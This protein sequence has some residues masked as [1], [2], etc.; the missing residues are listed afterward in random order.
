MVVRKYED[1]DFNQ[2]SQWAESGW[3]KKY[4]AEQFPKTGFI[5]DDFAAIFL[6]STDSTVCFIENLITNKETNV[7]ER[8]DAIEMLL[9]AIFLEA[10]ELGFEIAYAT[11]GISPVIARALRHR[12]E[13]KTKQTLLIKQFIDPS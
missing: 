12:C 9:A 10:K 6:Y 3:G 8:H 4:R 5:V 2:V 7:R 1:G 11:T 13:I